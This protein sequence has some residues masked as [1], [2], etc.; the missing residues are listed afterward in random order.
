MSPEQRRQRALATGL[1]PYL[2]AAALVEAVALWQRDYADRPRFSLQGYVSELCRLFDLG[3]QRHQLHLSLVRAQS[4]PDARLAADPLADDRAAGAG[5][6]HPPTRAFQ[7]LMRALWASLG[8]ARAGQLRLDQLTDLRQADLPADTRAALE[9]WL[10][11]P[12]SELAALDQGSLRTLLNRGYV[13][14]CE[15]FG[16]VSA[17]RLLKDAGDRLRR[18]QPELG[19]ALNELL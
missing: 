19:Q 18:D 9:Y 10:N 6:R 16:P 7:G 4:L 11:H 8:E 5:D 12:R 2:D 17:D 3:E 1:A 15:R 13:L 14:L